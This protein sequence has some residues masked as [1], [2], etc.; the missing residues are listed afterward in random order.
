[1]DM[2]SALPTAIGI[3][4][5]VW[6]AAA[7]PAEAQRPTLAMLDAIQ[8]GLWELRIRGEESERICLHD[9]RRLL[10]RRHAGLTCDRVIVDDTATT[11]GVQ[12]TCR[13]HGYGLTRIRRESAQVLQ[14]DSQG[15]EDGLPFEFNA[16]VRRIGN[17]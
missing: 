14:M 3:L 1:M 12:Y 4:G 6:A 5:L 2:K 17:C 13:G 9:G 16:E 7:V 10:Q 11:V 15:V 8:P